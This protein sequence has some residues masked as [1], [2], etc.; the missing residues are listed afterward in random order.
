MVYRH[1]YWR[2]VPE[3]TKQE[4]DKLAMVEWNAEAQGSDYMQLAT[5]ARAM[6]IFVDTWCDKPGKAAYLKFASDLLLPLV[7]EERYTSEFSTFALSSSRAPTECTKVSLHCS[8]Q[9]WLVESRA[10]CVEWD[11]TQTPLP[12]IYEL[13]CHRLD[14]GCNP[15]VAAALQGTG[16]L[17]VLHLNRLGLSNLKPLIDILNLSRN[18]EVCSVWARARVCSI[19][20][21]CTGVGAWA[22]GASGC[23]RHMEKCT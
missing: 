19:R 15:K 10:R 8:L 2:V 12:H 6:H 13:E 1:L 9:E 22:C 11:A 23:G 20:G 14:V 7:S 3:G 21:P 16:G 4:C 18:L 17:R 5:F